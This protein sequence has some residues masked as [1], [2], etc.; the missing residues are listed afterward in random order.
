MKRAQ[1]TRKVPRFDPYEKELLESFER[2]EWIPV[3]DQEAERA[4]LREYA[5]N[6]LKKL[7]RQERG[8]T[9]EP[10]RQNQRSVASGRRLIL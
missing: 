10:A 3:K 5:R 2:R 7:N 6:T 8:C 1:P 4:K 9:E